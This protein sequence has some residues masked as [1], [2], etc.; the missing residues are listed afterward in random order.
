M[1]TWNY[2]RESRT[3]DQPC[4]QISRI[5]QKSSFPS[6][7]YLRSFTWILQLSFM[8]GVTLADKWKGDGHGGSMG[9]VGRGINVF[10]P[11]D[12]LSPHSCVCGWHGHWWQGMAITSQTGLRPRRHC[13]TGWWW[14]MWALSLPPP[15]AALLPL[16]AMPSASWPW[17]GC[18]P[19]DMLFGWMFILKCWNDSFG[20]THK[21]VWAVMA[22]ALNGQ[23]STFFCDCLSQYVPQGAQRSVD[24]SFLVI[25]GPR[26][27]WLSS[28]RPQAGGT[29]PSDIR[30]V[31]DLLKFCR[32]C[33]AEVFCQAFSWVQ[34]QFLHL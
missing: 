2:L 26:D 10:P 22:K 30:A 11:W 12:S 6:T 33:K 20:L 4:K 24:K 7:F 23:G 13:S 15:E 3:I 21:H 19:W 16:A 14:I 8:V 18:L 28:T 27:V 31:P 25:P 17:N 1:S 29:L 5:R 32:A 34:L 9:G